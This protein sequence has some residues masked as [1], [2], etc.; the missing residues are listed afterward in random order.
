MK[1]SETK[2]AKIIEGTNQYMVPHYQRPYTW[3]TKEWKTLWADLVDLAE[4]E[5]GPGSNPEIIGVPRQHFM[6]SLVTAPGRSV[7]EGVSKWVLIDGQQ[8]LTT[9]LLLLAALRDHSRG[10][11]RERLGSQIHDLYLTNQYQDGADLYKLLPTA[12]STESGGDRAAFVA[13]IDGKV[14]APGNIHRAYQ[15][16]RDKFASS[17]APDPDRLKQIVV[18]SL[19]L[20]SIVLDR[21]DNPYLVFESLNA[22]GQQL[23]QADLIRNYFFMRLRLEHHDDI[24]KTRWRPMEDRLGQ[25][26]TTEFIRHFLMMSGSVVRISDIYC[27]L[28]QRLDSASEKIVLDLLDQLGRASQ[29]YARLLDPSLE[30][31]LGIQKALL[32]LNRL[33]ATVTYPFLLNIYKADVPESELV[34]I[35]ATLENFILRRYVCR[36]L[37]AELNKLFPTLYRNAQNYS[38]IAKGVR[39]ILAARSYP[40]DSQFRAD[41]AQSVL[42]GTGGRRERLKFILERI[43]DSFGHKERVDLST[44]SVEHVMP[45]S[46]TPWWRSHLGPDADDIHDGLL[47]TLGNLTL[48][49]TNAELS[50]LAFPEKQALLVESHLDLNREI[51]KSAKWGDT[52][53][54]KRGSDLAD[55]ALIIWPDLHP[56]RGSGRTIEAVTGRTPQRLIFYGHAHDVQ[57]WAAVLQVTMAEM[58]K[59]GD[60]VFAEI[61][62]QLPRYVSKDAGK[63]RTARRLDNGF[64]YESHLNA[65]QVNQICNQVTQLAGLSYEDWAL[66]VEGADAGG[67]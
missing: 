9:L 54:R 67:A 37:R 25:D 28:K 20:V 64:F 22:K 48:T 36:T 5:Q 55:R 8:R 41:L 47:H 16:F 32:R 56:G 7:P 42:Y 49:G 21:D 4:Q 33:E 52:E 29:H 66:E 17:G 53:I 27:E 11:N 6:G 39:E 65:K 40:S 30:P 18:G 51:S 34:D 57:T 61:A 24:Y 13:I 46:I 2:L 31:R 43:E 63:M 15:F 1:A 10:N 14:P 59:L 3:G 23:T 62:S 38:S 45:Q 35:L 26:N 50:N 44:L 12:D 58:A 60:D 19:I